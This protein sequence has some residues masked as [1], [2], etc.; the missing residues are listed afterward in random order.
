MSALSDADRCESGR[1]GVSLHRQLITFAFEPQTWSN[2]RLRRLRSSVVSMRQA[3][4]CNPGNEIGQF[5][6]KRLIDRHP[7]WILCKQ[8]AVSYE[9]AALPHQAYGCAESC[10]LLCVWRQEPSHKIDRGR[11]I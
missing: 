6:D 5:I 8:I 7:E 10:S 3:A 1:G 4:D 2:L 11:K 9:N